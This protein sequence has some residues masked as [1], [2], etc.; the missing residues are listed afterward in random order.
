VGIAAFFGKN[1]GL[2]GFMSI[3]ITAMYIW[4][5]VERSFLLK[6]YASF[7]G[8]VSLGYSPVFIMAIFIP[9]FFHEFIDSILFL[10]RQGGTNLPLPVPWTWLAFSSDAGG[11]ALVHYLSIS[12]IFFLMPLLYLLCLVRLPFIKKE[13]IK[14]NALLTAGLFTGVFY[15]H[16]VFSRA[17]I[18][19][20]ARGIH[21]LI[22]TTAALLCL[23]KGRR[24]RTAFIV[25]TG[26]FFASVS[27]FSIMP[28][29]PFFKK[30]YTARRLY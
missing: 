7:I 27:I 9:G 2:Y 18:E 24:I 29:K 1:M 28:E 13:D 21:P 25:F 26:L 30:Y 6:R 3:S 11:A 12:L 23:F 20:L 14:R 10:F 5:R 15:M 22:L 4:L 8:G 19:H 16:P 17:D